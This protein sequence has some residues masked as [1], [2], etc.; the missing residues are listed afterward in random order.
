MNRVLTAPVGRLSAWLTVALGL[1]VAV[2]LTV[3]A[4]A[5]HRGTGVS[6]GLPS[7]T[8]SVQ[9]AELAK[10][11]PGADATSALVVV[12]RDGGLLP[13]DTAALQ[14]ASQSIA[15]LAE[16]GRVA[17]PVTSQDGT[18]ALVAVPLSN[19]GGTDALTATVKE[20]RTELRAATAD[21]PSGLTAQVTGG[22]AFTTDIAAQ[23]EGANFT[24]LLTT[25]LVV[26]ALLL[27]TYRSPVLWLVPLAVVGASAAA[28]TALFAVVSR[29][30]GLVLDPSTGGIAD[31]LVFGAGTNY[32]LLLIARYREEL[33]READRRVAMRRAWR[34]AAP[35]I[36]ASAGTVVLSLLMLS[37]AVLGSNRS[38][39]QYGALGIAV[40]A[41]F[42]LF[43]LPAALVV[44]GRGVFWPFVPRLGS[45]ET[46]LSGPWSRIGRGVV[47][48][49]WRVVAVAVAVLAVMAAGLSGARLGLSQTEQ[50]R[51]KAE[52]VAGVE[53][54]AKA[55]PAGAADP[56]RIIVRS[57][58]PAVVG[59]VV[60]AVSST[61]G[62]ASATAGRQAAGAD[63]GSGLTEV[64]AVLDGDPSSAAAQTT[65]ERL[66]TELDSVAGE[67]LV[68]GSSADSLDVKVATERDLRVVAPLVLLVVLAVLVVLLRAV[69][70][71]IVLV[72][73]VVASFFAAL[74][75]GNWLATSVL[76]YPGLDTGVPLLAFLF[77]VALGVDYNIFLVTRVREEV[78]ARGTREAVVVGVS[79]TG[80]VITSAG[81]LLAAVF[82]VLGVLPLITL[83]ELGIIVGIGVL[84]DTLL[85]RTL[86]VPVLF[87]LLDRR[88]WWPGALS[89]AS[90]HGGRDGGG[91]GGGGNG[92]GDDVPPS[93]STP[94]LI[95]R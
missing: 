41:L 40:A 65:V 61:E 53:T 77:L 44:C 71:P 90:H 12:R 36:A 94:E 93:T 3:L 2:G 50:F 1:L 16:G 73:T 52:A 81:V 59:A 35:A 19:A 20:I 9:V 34:G 92:G 11:L 14:E 27:V 85:V 70:G 78:P 67:A 10:Q 63:G 21:L 60:D 24:L 75:A 84:L 76:G 37:F 87:T 31:V 51:V 4:P 39:G 17:P 58:D 5:P 29:T 82:T 66:R 23:F 80:A 49:P 62:V 15:A 25:V 8:E 38:V 57:T 42:A 72:V 48:R 32:A 88:A 28:A 74:G 83:T 30:F 47:K 64:T 89:R 95:T 26:A 79:V 54:L 33:R 86:L 7:S 55:F 6:A 13:A 46:S 91:N 18:T 69:V 22:A 68:G 43:V 56:A 45:A